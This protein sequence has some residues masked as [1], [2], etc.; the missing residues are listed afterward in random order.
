[1]SEFIKTQQELRNNLITQVREVLDFADSEARGLDAAELSKINAI[2]AD[3]A[4]ADNSSFRRSQGIYSGCIR[5][6]FRN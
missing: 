4:K 5:G 1:M 6:T 3:I 2:E